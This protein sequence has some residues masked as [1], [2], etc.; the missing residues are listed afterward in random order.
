MEACE[1][2]CMEGDSVVACG[3]LLKPICA[4]PCS[5]YGDLMFDVRLLRAPSLQSGLRALARIPA[6]D[7]Q[8]V[9]MHSHHSV[10]FPSEEQAR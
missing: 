8:C 1:R 4:I 6:A 9:T 10:L 2:I 5:S 7:A 3:G